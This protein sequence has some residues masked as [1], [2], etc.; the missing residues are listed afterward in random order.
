MKRGKKLL[1]YVMVALMAMQVPAIPVRA[2]RVGETVD[3]I[4]EESVDAPRFE[5]VTAT[6]GDFGV[7]NGL[8]WEYD[9]ETKTVTVSGEDVP[10]VGWRFTE[11]WI[12]FNSVFPAETEK[13]CFE[14]CSI[15]SHMSYFF[16]CLSRLREIDFTGLEINNLTSTRRMFS[17]CASL[18]SLDLRGFDTSDVTDMED[19]FSYCSSLSSINMCGLDTSNVLQMGYMF[20]GC[21]NLKSIDLSGF[22]TGKV[23]DMGAMFFDCSNLVSLDLCGFDTGNLISMN[24]MFGGC[25]SLTTL[26]TPSKMGDIT[27]DLPATFYTA[28]GTATTVLS[29]DFAGTT[30]YKE[31]HVPQ[32]VTPLAITTQPVSAEVKDG[33]QATFTVSATGDGLTYRWQLCYAGDDTFRTCT[34]PGADTATL[35]VDATKARNGYSFRCVVTDEHGSSVTSD[36]ATLTV[37]TEVALGVALT[38]SKTTADSGEIVTFTAVG[39][40]G[41][42]NYQYK[43]IINDTTNDKWY[44]LQDYSANNTIEWTATTA[45]TKRI[46]VDIKD[47]TG[48]SVGKNVSV[49]V[50]G[51]VAPAELKATL[52]A[53]SYEVN[54]G[55]VV[56]LTA[57][58]LGGSG[59]YNY[60]FIINDKT[61]DKWYRLQDYGT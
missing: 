36:V 44:K 47:G 12:P 38:A 11:D 32:P 20:A 45:G 6:S 40:G 54:S 28:D 46:M 19:M 3:V 39:N 26:A 42:G 41:D 18:T 27:T 4:V 5:A 22:D 9:T 8:H 16:S 33:S 25:D 49:V 21:R 14:N 24:Y 57:Q 23:T 37:K 52:T 61:D 29:K 15:S 56:T 17:S 2:A 1:L 35:T 59:K 10:N 60:K 30:L 7:N 53:S 43:F 50:N 31:G 13:F 55:E 51:T 34:F 58:A 48:K